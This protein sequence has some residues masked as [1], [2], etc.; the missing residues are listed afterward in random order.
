MA[1]TSSYWVHDLSPFLIRF[2][3]N[4]LGL[5]GI[6]YYGLSYLLGFLAAWALLRAYDNRGKFAIN[7]DARATLMT[8]VILGVIAGGRIGYM[9]LY[10]LEAFLQNPALILRVDQGG[11]ASHGGFIGVLLAVVWFAKKYNTNFFKLGDVIV[12]LA[13]LGICF[14]RI[15]NFWNG[16]LWGR[17]TD[18]RYAVIFPDS[19]QVYDAALRIFAPEPRHA[20]QLYAA[21]LEGALLFAYSQ[22]RFWRT[23]PPAGQLGGEFLIGY[24]IVR[25]LGEFFREPD[26]ALIMG[27]SRGQFYSIFM[28]IAGIAIIRIARRKQTTTAA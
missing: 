12:T 7:A 15:A 17:V 4:P 23:N 19:P 3:E 26:A 22:W 21:V 20:S 27:L 16:E 8:A 9:L 11:M 5:D 1:T 28:I 6:R 2:P 18:M 14:G 13:P 24:G 25:I 10:D